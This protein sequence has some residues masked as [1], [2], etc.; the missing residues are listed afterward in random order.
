M[1][2][3]GETAAETVD[4]LNERGGKVGVLKVRLFRPFS[5]KRFIERA[6]GE[7]KAMAVLDRTKESGA[8]GEPLYL[9]IVT[10]LSE[11]LASGQCK[12]KSMPK[13]L[14]GRY[15]LS[16][17]DFTPAMVKAVFDNLQAASSKNHFTVGIRGRRHQQQPGVRSGLLHRVGRRSCAR[18]STGW[19][20]TARS[21]RTRTRSRS[22][23]KTPTTTPKATSS[24]IRK[25]RRSDHLPPA[26]R[27]EADSLDLPGEQGQLR[28]LPPADFP[29]SLRHAQ[30]PGA[31]RDVPA[32]HP[33]T[34]PRKSGTSSR[35]RSRKP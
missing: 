6:A 22:S 16:S 35:G 14:G 27:A 2:S 28:R 11:S 26:F 20:R 21:A 25:G 5:L 34:A 32:Q 10:A 30:V 23:A 3:G 18:C 19:A 7:R 13:V 15:G 31:R 8:L 4:Y 17:K 24:T 29:G 1:G 9:D 33:T 12:L